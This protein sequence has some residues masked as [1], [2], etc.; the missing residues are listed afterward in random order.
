MILEPAE[1]APICIF[2]SGGRRFIGRL[3]SENV[4][5]GEHVFEEVYEIVATTAMY[6]GGT[7][8]TAVQPQFPDFNVLINEPV[9]RM[10]VYQ[11]DWFYVPDSNVLDKI[12]DLI[13]KQLYD[14][15]ENG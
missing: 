4:D 10:A 1:S 11:L 13:Q 2:S 12:K 8:I 3:A 9:K 6:T 7:T 5:K 14:G 15:K